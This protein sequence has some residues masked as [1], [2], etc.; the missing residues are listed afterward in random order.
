ML[1]TTTVTPHDL[2]K[3]VGLLNWW[4]I[5]ICGSNLISRSMHVQSTTCSAREHW[6][7]PITLAEPAVE[8][9]MFCRDN[10]VRIAE[11][12]MPIVIPRFEELQTVWKRSDVQT[13]HYGPTYR[14]CHDGGTA[15]WG[16][17]LSRGPGTQDLKESGEYPS[18]FVVLGLCD[19]QPW[20]EAITTLLVLKT[21]DPQ[22]RG[23]ALNTVSY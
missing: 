20:R 10:N 15:H 1:Q 21:F 5:G 4:S 19:N 8:E 18:Y 16:A 9:L 14:L 12:G 17:T 23:F 13:T 11:F 22:I 7:V 6:D 2:E 3:V